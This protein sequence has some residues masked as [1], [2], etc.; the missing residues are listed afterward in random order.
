VRGKR[1]SL[2]FLVSFP[3]AAGPVGLPRGEESLSY[4]LFCFVYA[5]EMGK[6]NGGVGLGWPATKGGY[7]EWIPCVLMHGKVDLGWRQVANPIG[8]QTYV[9]NNPFALMFTINY[10]V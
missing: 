7:F 5:R 9:C 8:H 2:F 6:S 4:S 1:E 10:I 3:Q